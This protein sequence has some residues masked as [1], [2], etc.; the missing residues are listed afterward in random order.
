LLA[1]LI[2]RR[3]GR[4]PRILAHRAFFDF[5]DEIKKVSESFG[6]KKA[7]IQNGIDE[8][9]KD[10]LLIL[11]PEGEEGNFKS[12][13]FSY[14][15]QEFHTGFLRM[16]LQTHTPIIAC[17]IIGAEESHI[18]LG[19]ID[20]SAFI[21]GLRIPIPLNV[22]PLPAKWKI[23]FMP[24]IDLSE[25]DPKMADDPETLKR[26]AKRIRVKMQLEIR[27]ELKKRPYIY[28]EKGREILDKFTNWLRPGQK[29][30]SGRRPRG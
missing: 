19:N 25:F 14:R 20:L 13:F 4:L 30:R 12:S 24:P 6:L 18:N 23:K 1:H 9:N 11:F 8:L 2:R 17:V 29:H 16:A 3:A 22:I 27:R 10:E 21:K 5:S 7:S 26:L 28:T 15:L